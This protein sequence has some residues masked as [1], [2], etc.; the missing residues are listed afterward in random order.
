MLIPLI[1]NQPGRIPPR[2]Q[3]DA[4]VNN[5]DFPHTI[6]D[7]LGQPPLEG[8]GLPGKSYAPM[9][10]RKKRPWN[11]V[12]FGEY[13]YARMIRTERWKYVQRTEGFSS[14]LYDLLLDAGER[15]NLIKEPDQA[16]RVRE[17]REDLNRWFAERGCASPDA[18]KSTRQILPTYKAQGVGGQ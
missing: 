11:N 18:W 17:M 15:W 8:K 5:Y 16:E 9:L 6:L 13:Q 12:V 1:Y 10:E 7:Y 4:M 3:I 14:E 2:L